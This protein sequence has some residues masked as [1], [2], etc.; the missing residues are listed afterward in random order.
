MWDK[1]RDVMLSGQNSP[2][3]VEYYPDNGQEGDSVGLVVRLISMRTAVEGSVELP[4]V[5]AILFVEVP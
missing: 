5:V 2:D 4:I 3:A 1:L